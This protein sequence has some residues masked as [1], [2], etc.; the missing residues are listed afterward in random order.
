MLQT[1]TN[2][3]AL[4]NPPK[5]LLLLGLPL[6]LAIFIVGSQPCTAQP[7]P[8]PDRII[9]LPG[10]TIACIIPGNPRKETAL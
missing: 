2:I 4:K 1:I 5:A 8:Y 7:N 6:V 3:N 9:T 10:D